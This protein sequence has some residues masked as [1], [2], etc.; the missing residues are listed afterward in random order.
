MLQ[1]TPLLVSPLTT[2]PKCPVVCIK[3]RLTVMAKIFQDANSAKFPL[4]YSWAFCPFT[5]GPAIG[6]RPFEQVLGKCAKDCLVYG[7]CH[8]V[9]TDSTQKENGSG[10]GFKPFLNRSK[11]ARALT[12][13]WSFPKMPGVRARGKVSIR[14]CVQNASC[15]TLPMAARW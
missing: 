14:L 7:G 4:A 6:C 11:D 13:S 10:T 1:K 9:Y 15:S 2:F 8:S 5:L 12:W 3:S